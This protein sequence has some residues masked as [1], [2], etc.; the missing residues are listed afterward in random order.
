MRVSILIPSF[1]HEAFVSEAIDSALAS[2]HRDL[3]VIVVDDGSTDDTR[4]RLEEF[5]GDRRVQ[6]FTQENQGA[7]AALNR[8]MELATG[9]V[10]FILNSDDAFFPDRVPRLVKELR[11][12]P[13]TVLAASWIQIVDVDGSE[14]GIK[15]GWLNLPPWSP[16]SRGPYLS[17]LGDPVLALLET[18][19]LATTSNIAFPRTLVTDHGLQFRALR[20]AHDWDFILSACHHGEI[21]LVPAP[22][23]K[24]RAHWDNT[25]REGAAES[26]GEMRFEIQWVVARHAFRL[27]RAARHRE[28]SSENLERLLWN[29]M[30]SF[31]C[32][33]ILDRLLLLRGSS[34]DPPAAYDSAMDPSHPLYRESIAVLAQN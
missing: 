19:Y 8:A 14:C 11:E 2:Q 5:R 4:T 15:K 24:Y 21:A 1:N 26:V 29:S 28:L 22:L 20:Y 13:D 10:F 25:I 16:P 3:E 33:S 27:L 31:G 32:D 30:P 17:N 6:V 9:D 7:H 12:Q 23:V 18:N 34:D